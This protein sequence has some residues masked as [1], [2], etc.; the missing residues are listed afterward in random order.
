MNWFKK[1]NSYLAYHGSPQDFK[2]FSYEFMGNTGTAEGFGFYFTSV[3]PPLPR[4]ER[5]PTN[6][7]LTSSVY[8]VG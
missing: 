6:Y 1:A 2:E 7:R 4:G 5:I 8:L 3:E